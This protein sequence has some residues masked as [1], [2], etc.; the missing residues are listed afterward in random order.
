MNSKEIATMA[1]YEDKHWWHIGKRK[2]VK[3]LIMRNFAQVDN[4]IILEVGCGTG[5]N[6][7]MLENFGEVTGLD[8]SK[9]ALE[10]CR[11]NGFENVVL[12]DLAS[13]LSGLPYAEF[14]LII[15][16]DVLEHIQDDVTAIKNIYN[17]LKDD[18]ILIVTVPACKLLWSSHD[19][20][21][22][23]KRR[24]SKNELVG[25]LCD[26]GFDMVQVSYFVFFLF[27]FLFGLRFLQ[28][29]FGRDVYPR[30]RYYLPPWKLNELFV[31]MLDFEIFLLRSMELFLG[32]TLFVVGR[33]PK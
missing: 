25:R 21:L 8:I 26:N 7:R 14:D 5:E 23:H 10:H 2:L 15:A 17:L 24:Y 18:G 12:G 13:G 19:E 9:E 22:E 6:L 4:L 20:A 31:K 16:L 28:N 27:P 11:K 32:S 33:K 30:T 1:Y 29:V 3:A